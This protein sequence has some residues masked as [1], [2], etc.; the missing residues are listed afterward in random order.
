MN[1]FDLPRMAFQS[2]YVAKKSNTLVLFSDPH[3]KA[4]S[5]DYSR[6]GSVVSAGA[7]S[8]RP[9]VMQVSDFYLLS[10]GFQ[11]KLFLTHSVTNK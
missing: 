7:S 10:L 6:Q 5:K 4:G 9:P 11:E 1:F 8:L 3:P 2:Q